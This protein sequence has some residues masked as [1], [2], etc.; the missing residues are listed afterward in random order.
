MKRRT[1]L[2]TLGT[3]TVAAAVTGGFLFLGDG[4]DA[5][6]SGRGG[7]L[8]PATTAVVRTDLVQSKTVDGKLDFAQR[9]AVKSA[10]E[11][12]VTVAASEGRTVARGQTLY[13]LNDKPVTLLYGPV[14]MFREMKAGDRGSDV[15]QLERN[16]RD[17]GFGPKLYVDPWYDKDTEAAVKQW[18][19]TL[20]RDT[21]GRVGKGDVV[22]Q[23]DRVKVAEAD[24]AL[25][26]QVVPGGTVLTIASTRPVVRAQLEQTDGALTSSGTKVEVTLPSGKTV[27][28]KVAGTVRP[29]ESASEGGAVA[30]EGITVE[31]VLDGGAGAA[32]G[33][34]AKASASVKF[35]SEARRGVLAVPIE[36]VVALRG[37]NGGYG[38]QVVRGTTSKMVRV[39]TGMTADGQIEVSGPDVREG[40]KVGVAKS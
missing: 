21:T 11:G 18:Q 38:L 36:A 26:D 15:L 40:M 19:K 8:P 33:E 6:A 27:A 23:P 3:V 25:A 4:G 37:E 14:P 16:L 34:D 35:V 17:L 31:V 39:E 12:T 29:E 9:R 1:A 13:E 5:G 28:G 10:V 30:P 2:L 22:F 7:D 20:N 32:S 24:A